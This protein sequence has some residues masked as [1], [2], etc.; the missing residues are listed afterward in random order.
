MAFRDPFEAMMAYDSG[1]IGLHAI[2]KVRVDKQVADDNQIPSEESEDK[3]GSAQTIETTVGRCIFN[4]MLPKEM[5]F[6]NMIMSKK[7]LGRV[8][9]DCYQLSGSSFTVDLLD[10]IKN[11]GFKHAT[12]AGL[13]FGV[14]DL[15][16]PAKK[17]EIIK[18]CQ[19]SEEL[20]K[21]CFDGR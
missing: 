16:I 7:V 18:N 2:V 17:E 10:N 11:L 9:S 13:S 4:D 14:T 19:D 8:I 21:R 20:S 1:K 12:L 15:K 6:Y 3:G 5:P